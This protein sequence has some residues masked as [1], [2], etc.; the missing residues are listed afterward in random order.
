MRLEAAAWA[1]VFEHNF[2][3]SGGSRGTSK[4]VVTRPV[5]IGLVR[6]GAVM[7]FSTITINTH[8]KHPATCNSSHLWGQQGVMEP[9]RGSLRS[10]F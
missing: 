8:P 10:G 2:E 1:T 6:G 9:I 3:G 5:V 7:S 4:C